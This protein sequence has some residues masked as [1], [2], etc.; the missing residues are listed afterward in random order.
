VPT[1]QP[2]T[3]QFSTTP[4]LDIPQPHFVSI[5]QKKLKFPQ[6]IC[7]ISHK[8]FVGMY[9]FPIHATCHA[10]HRLLLLFN[11]KI[12][13]ERYKFERVY[14]FLLLSMYSYCC[15]C[16]LIVVYVFLLLSIY[17]YCCLCILIVVYVFLL[18]S[19]YSYCCLCIFIVV[20]VFLLLSMYSYCCLCIL[21]V[22]YI[23]LLLS[24]YSYC[25]LRILRRGY[26]DWGFSSAVR[27]MPGYN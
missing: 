17:S 6:F 12:L 18:L 24:M 20:Y 22:V 14:V 7:K 8:N 11:L 21:I 25:C 15:L 2:K 19:I 3:L 1:S 10:Y 26:P 4:L 23:F 27:K 16:I 9:Y 5:T 13:G